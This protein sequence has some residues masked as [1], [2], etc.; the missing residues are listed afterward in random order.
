MTDS[1]AGLGQIMFHMLY[2]IQV[3]ENGSSFWRI[4]STSFLTNQKNVETM[5][6]ESLYLHL[7]DLC[8]KLHIGKYS[9]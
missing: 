4:M 7:R 2:L 6:L 8:E 3:I 5:L 9:T 1:L